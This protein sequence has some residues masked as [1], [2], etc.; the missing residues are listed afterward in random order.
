MMHPKSCHSEMFFFLIWY[1]SKTT[2]LSMSVKKKYFLTVQPKSESSTHPAPAKNTR[3]NDTSTRLFAQKKFLSH[4]TKTLQKFEVFGD[5]SINS[6]RNANIKDKID[7]GPSITQRP[8]RGGFT[9]K[10]HPEGLS[11]FAK[12]KQVKH[13]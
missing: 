6:L 7:G 8:I 12:H 3:L 10:N 9:M 2:F 5:L 4:L 1:V 11:F 13:S